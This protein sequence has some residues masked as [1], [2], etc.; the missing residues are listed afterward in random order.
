[1]KHYKP[2]L[3]SISDFFLLFL[4]ISIGAWLFAEGLHLII[5]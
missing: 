4:K 1:M 3:K 5:G 2:P